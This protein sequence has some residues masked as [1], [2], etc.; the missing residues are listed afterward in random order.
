MKLRLRHDPSGSHLIGLP[1]SLALADI[2]AT[3][4]GQPAEYWQGRFELAH[5]ANPLVVMALRISPWLALP[6]AVAWLFF[7]ASLMLFLPPTGRRGAF[8][9]LSIAHLVFVWGWIVRWDLGC[10]ILFSGIAFLVALQIHCQARADGRRAATL[11][12]NP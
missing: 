12:L 3:L 8:L 6:G 9:F 7:V 10:G 4:L 11:N 5:D 1:S 2:G